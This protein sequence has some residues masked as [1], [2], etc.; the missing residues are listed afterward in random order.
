MRLFLRK[1]TCKKSGYQEATDTFIFDSASKIARQNVVVNYTG[2]GS[3]A[4]EKASEEPSGS[5][6]VHSGWANHFE[7]FGKQ[8]VE[9]ILLDYT[10][11]SVITVYNQLDGKEQEFKGLSG[12]TECFTGLFKSLPD[13]SALGAPIQHV[14]EKSATGPGEVFLVWSCPSSGYER[15]TD[16]FIFNEDGKIVR[17]N[18]V[19]AYAPQADAKPKKTKGPRKY[20]CC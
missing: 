1:S 10:E 15:A 16:T 13:C 6:K 14:E 5:G 7:A 11:D 12:A 3:E 17:Q 9:Q 20:G 18:V 4:G 19:V 2:P 8:N